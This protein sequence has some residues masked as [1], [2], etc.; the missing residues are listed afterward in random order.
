[1][2]RLLESACPRESCAGRRP[3]RLP[4][5][6]VS[7]EKLRNRPRLRQERACH[8]AIRESGSRQENRRGRRPRPSLEE[9]FR[10]SL[11]DIRILEAWVARYRNISWEPGRVHRPARGGGCLHFAEIRRD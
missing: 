8:G 6:E 10:V 1:M 2:A 5:S 3:E 9:R 4:S 7:W 11:Q